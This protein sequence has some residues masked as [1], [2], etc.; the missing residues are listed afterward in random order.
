MKQIDLNALATPEI[1]ETP[2]LAQ[3]LIT[4][5]KKTISKKS[6]AVR[7]LYGIGI[8]VGIAAIVYLQIEIFDYTPKASSVINFYDNYVYVN[9]TTT[10]P[11]INY[12]TQLQIGMPRTE[13]S[14]LNGVLFTKTQMEE[15][16]QRRPLAVMVNNLAFSRP[17][18]NL[19]Q[20]DIVYETLVESGIT[21]YM[22]IFWSNKVEEVGP[23]RS[24]RNYYL[25]I[26]GE[27]D[28]ILSHDGQAYSDDPR[29]DALGNLSKYGVKTART[30]GAW[31]WND[32]VRYA[33]HNEYM[34]PVKVWEYAKSKD[35]WTGFGP[36]RSWL[37]KKDA[38]VDERGKQTEVRVSFTPDGGGVNQYSALW[39]YNSA[40]NKYLREIGGKKDIDQKTKLQ[41]EPKVVIVQEAGYLTPPDPSGRIIMEVIDEGNAKILQDGKIYSA[42]WKKESRT[43]RTL[44]Y[45]EDGSE[46]VFNRGQIWIQIIPSSRGSFTIIKQ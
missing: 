35:G 34:S 46:F 13:P 41:Q 36:T 43:E 29:L 20:A 30:Y 37:F 38:D 15:M 11:D 25:E 10:A 2:D 40:T 45:A 28:A 7:I 32:G 22:P 17:Q 1:K 14:P 44:F 3:T 24:V 12:S 26:V 9:S 8:V 4:E 21:R 33:P 6:I 42:T 23:I 19:S 16:M 39:I 27:Y 5:E 31:R 18:S